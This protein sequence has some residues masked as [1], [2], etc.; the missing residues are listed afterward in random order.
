MIHIINVSNFC[1]LGSDIMVENLA[2]CD[3]QE[4]INSFIEKRKPT[5]SHS[6]NKA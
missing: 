1:R 3:A 4:G 2:L 6:F 5:W